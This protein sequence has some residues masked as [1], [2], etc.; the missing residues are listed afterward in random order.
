MRAFHRRSVCY[1]MTVC[2]ILDLT[3]NSGISFVTE[4]K[5]IEAKFSKRA[6]LQIVSYQ[7]SK[8]RH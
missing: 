4:N 5:T 2:S 7:T 6:I 1:L 3:G 8:K